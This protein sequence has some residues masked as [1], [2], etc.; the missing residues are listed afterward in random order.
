MRQSTIRLF[1]IMATISIVGITAMQLFWVKR[2]FDLKETQFNHNVNL[3]LKQ[4]AQAILT[5]NNHK[6]PAANTVKQ[7]SEDYFVVMV[8][9][10]IDANLLETLLRQEF[11]KRN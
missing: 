6:I 8:N 2:A 1:L 3:A 11:T 5:F 7:L 10:K 9:D 4:V